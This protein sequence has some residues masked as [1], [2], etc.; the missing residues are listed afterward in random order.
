[1]TTIKSFKTKKA[2]GYSKMNKTIVT[3]LPANMLDNLI[4]IFNASLSCGIFPKKFKKAI[5]KLLP[6]IG[7]DLKK[8]LNYRPISLLEMVGKI[9]EKSL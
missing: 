9:Y 8:V 7:K 6:K 3:N 1:M 5:L 2:P 4:H